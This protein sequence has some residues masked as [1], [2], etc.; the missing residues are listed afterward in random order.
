MRSCILLILIPLLLWG[1]AGASEVLVGQT[2]ANYSQIQAAIDGS[3]PGD[4]IR[5]QSG[6]Y[7]ENVNINKPLNLIGVDSGNGRPLV[8]AGGSGSVITIAASNTT[9]QGF[10]ITGSGG[11]GCGHSGIKVLSSNNLIMNNIIYK[12]KYGIYIEAAGA[13]NTFVSNDLINNSITISDSGKNTSWNAGTRSGGLRGILDM[14]SGP[15][16]VGNHYSDYDEVGEGCNDT[17]NDLICDKPKVIGSSL[18]SYP[19]ISATN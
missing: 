16:V 2:G 12:N 8:N 11:C 6:V 17:N 5:V 13:N 7:K 9:V 1:C 14:I 3:M 4:T 18:D 19:S 15:R 10:N